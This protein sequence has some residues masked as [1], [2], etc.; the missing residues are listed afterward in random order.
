MT[1]TEKLPLFI[2]GKSAKP[3][4]FKNVHSLPTEYTANKKA[5]MTVDI[6]TKWLHQIDRKFARQHR[7]IAM[8]IDNCPAHPQIKDLKATKL[9]FLPPNTTSKTQPMDQ[10]VIQNLK[11]HY[12]KRLILRHIKAIDRHQEL[13][14]S[15]L[16]AMKPLAVSWRCVTET[17]IKNCFHHAGFKI[18]DNPAPIDSD[19]DDEDDIPLAHLLSLPVPFDQYASV[20]SD[21]P[22]NATMTDDDIVDEIMQR[23]SNNADDQ[24]DTETVDDDVPELPLPTTDM[25]T[26]ACA[27]LIRVLETRP[28]KSAQIQTP[29]RISDDLI[30]EDL[31][32]Q[33]NTRTQSKISDYFS[34]FAC[35]RNSEH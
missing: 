8:V 21:V 35:Q 20:D 18:Y 1:G 27:L 33:T 6:F 7:R 9:I 19:D 12:R 14:I 5:W 32:A 22:T 28:N 34:D 13:Q 15:V 2:I 16:D 3:R 24:D 26:D 10:G 30:R 11:V 31:R 4:C 29:L 17:T 25:A 23:K